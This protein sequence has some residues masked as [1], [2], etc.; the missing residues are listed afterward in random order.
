MQRLRCW[1]VQ[2]RFNWRDRV[3]QM[4]YSQTGKVLLVNP[5]QVKARCALLDIIVPGVRQAKRPVS[6]ARILCMKV[7]HPS[8]HASTARK[9]NSHLQGLLAVPCAPPDHFQTQWLHPAVAGARLAR[10]LRHRGP[11]RA[12]IVRREN[13]AHQAVCR[14]LS[15]TSRW[16]SRSRSRNQ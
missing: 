9:V 4:R 2:Q 15:A 14:S 11:C 6:Q 3:H 8:P 13:Q 1:N 16:G 10:I 7:Q 5:C 12:Q